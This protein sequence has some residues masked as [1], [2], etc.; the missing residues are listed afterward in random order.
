MTRSQTTVLIVI[1]R[2][3]SVTNNLG[4]EVTNNYLSIG[5]FLCTGHEFL[6]GYI[7]DFKCKLRSVIQDVV[8]DDNLPEEIIDISWVIPL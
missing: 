7:V 5:S 6:K 4:L 2:Q 3:H 1:L 8:C